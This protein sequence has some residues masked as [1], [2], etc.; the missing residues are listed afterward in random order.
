MAVNSLSRNSHDEFDDWVKDDNEIGTTSTNII[1][2][3][4]TGAV[5]QNEFGF[6]EVKVI[7]IGEPRTATTPYVA[8]VNNAFGQLVKESEELKVSKYFSQPKAF[9]KV[10]KYP[11]TIF[12][13]SLAIVKI[14]L[15]L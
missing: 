1:T 13:K 7:N 6:A 12:K 10:N 3:Y 9:P 2:G 15:T 14:V 5:D 4:Y 11:D 8:Q